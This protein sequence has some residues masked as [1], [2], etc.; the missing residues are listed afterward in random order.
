MPVLMSV[1]TA[2]GVVLA[3]NPAVSAA[4]PDRQV[5]RPFA[6]LGRASEFTAG[7]DCILDRVQA[8]MGRAC[9]SRAGSGRQD[10]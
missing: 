7:L 3:P 9:Q 6:R 1:A 2:T 5:A 4:L 8:V 10:W